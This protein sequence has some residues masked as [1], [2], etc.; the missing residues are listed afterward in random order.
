MA[1]KRSIA[2]EIIGKL[3]EA[4]VALAQ[5]QAVG[6]V[7][8]RSGS[9]SRRTYRWRREYGG[10]RVDQAQTAAG[11]GAGEQPPPAPGGRPGAGQR[12]VAGRPRRETS[13]PGD[14]PPHGY[15]PPRAGRRLAAGLRSRT[16]SR[17]NHPRPSAP[18]AKPSGA[19]A[20]SSGPTGPRS[21]RQPSGP[22][23]IVPYLA[24][25]QA[26]S[27]DTRH[28][29]YREVHCFFRWL[30]TA[31]SLEN[32]PVPRPPQHEPHANPPQAGERVA[33]P[34]LSGKPLADRVLAPYRR[35]RAMI[36][37]IRA[38]SSVATRAG[39]RCVPRGGARTRQ[40]RRSETTSAVRAC[41]TAWR[42]RAGLRNFPTRP[43][44]G[45]RCPAPGRPPASSAARSRAPAPCGAA[46]GPP[47]GRR[48]PPPAGVRLLRDPEPPGDRAHVLPLGQGDL[49]L[50]PR[51]DDRLRRVPLPRHADSPRPAA[52]LAQDLDRFWGGQVRRD[53]V[54]TV[55]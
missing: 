46:P 8:A 18:T 26:H 51:A 11:A 3:R 27:L 38:G 17:A 41:V 25:Y 42:R 53:R 7:V 50:P 21:T 33:D 49:R 34:L 52:I 36:R 29:Y 9:A 16:P 32:E 5:G 12:D 23:H 15:P 6:A 14:A 19:S 39:W 48:T 31:G 35:A 13:E 22:D 55:H 37:A 4:E 20:R 43:P 2:E 54:S 44:C 24:R 40:A 10:L 28:R 45:W 30:R 1:R 47:A